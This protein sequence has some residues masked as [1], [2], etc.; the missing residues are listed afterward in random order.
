MRL[1]AHIAL[2][3]G[4]LASA[5]VMVRARRSSWALW[6]LGIHTTCLAGIALALG[7]T[8]VAALWF[9]MGLS[10]ALASGATLAG[11]KPPSQN[12]DRE[13][14]RL[15][16]LARILLGVM[17][18]I[19]LAGALI[20]EQAPGSLIPESPLAAPPG[21]ETAALLATLFVRYAPAAI[22]VGLIALVATLALRPREREY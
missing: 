18:A 5:I 22:G 8:L 21:E 19:S 3:V 17:L 7:N 14:S 10:I 13:M 1:A 20:V 4:A 6:G 12:G 11:D 16:A 9:A 15:R 2:L